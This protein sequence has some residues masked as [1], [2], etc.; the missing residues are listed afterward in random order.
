MNNLYYIADTLTNQPI[1]EKISGDIIN[2]SKAVEL[3]NEQWQKIAD[4]QQ[5]LEGATTESATLS[6]TLDSIV[7]IANHRS[8][9]I[10]KLL[11]EKEKL[12]QEN[13]RLKETIE[14]LINHVNYQWLLERRDLN[15][16]EVVRD[17]IRS[18]EELIENKLQARKRR[19][20]DELNFSIR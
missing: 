5:Q 20:R 6:E 7:I 8:D 13:E 3:L 10:N 15:M 16:S 2:K 4:L 1:R 18:F 9:S 11:A 12:E 17:K 19:G 14:Y